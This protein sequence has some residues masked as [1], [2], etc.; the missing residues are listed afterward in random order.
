[1]TLICTDEFIQRIY[2]H[3]EAETSLAVMVMT[4]FAVLPERLRR[5]AV[6]QWTIFTISCILLT[7]RETFTLITYIP[8]LIMT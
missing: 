3:G 6:W 1:M 5:M 8:K 4:D 2:S 7:V